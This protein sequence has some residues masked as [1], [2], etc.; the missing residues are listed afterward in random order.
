[1]Y[2]DE[3]NCI[4]KKF[5]GQEVMDRITGF[6]G[7]ATQVVSYLNMCDRIGIQPLVGKDGK[8]ADMDWFD[9][10]QVDIVGGTKLEEKEFKNKTGGY[11]KPPAAIKNPS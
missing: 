5:L 3:K 1:M 4:A 10:M 6:K 2:K 9:H 7:I 11:E 8:M